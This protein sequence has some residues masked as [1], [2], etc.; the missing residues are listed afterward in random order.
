MTGSS[1]K[2][3]RARIKSSA[4]ANDDDHDLSSRREKPNFRSRRDTN[5]NSSVIRIFNVDLKLMLGLI[6]LAFFI[7]LL[8]IRNLI[9]PV[10]IAQRPRVV[11]PFPAPKLMDLPQVNC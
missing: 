8:L 6:V 7:I 5:R 2:S 4:H 10:D 3:A 1:S 9:K 11:T